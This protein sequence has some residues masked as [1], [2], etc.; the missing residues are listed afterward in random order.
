M[1][2]TVYRHFLG[3]GLSSAYYVYMVNAKM[4][5][6]T[7]ELNWLT[8]MRCVAMFG[9][10]WIQ[11]K[12]ILHQN[13]NSLNYSIFSS[14]ERQTFLKNFVVSHPQVCVKF[15]FFKKSV[16]SIITSFAL[17]KISI[18]KAYRQELNWMKIF[19]CRG[20]FVTRSAFWCGNRPIKYIFFFKHFT[21]LLFF[22]FILYFTSIV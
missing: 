3:H 18:C 8:E 1:N 21:P 22:C 19:Y 11:L 9:T 5:F 10:S 2:N 6:P 16:K 4:F 13:E 12:W 15:F 20:W 17:L 7:I 14:K